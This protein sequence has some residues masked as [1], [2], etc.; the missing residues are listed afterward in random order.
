MGLQFEN[1]DISD[2]DSRK[3]EV[4]R[5][6]AHA[7]KTIGFF[8]ISGKTSSQA[9]RLPV[10]AEPVRVRTAPCSSMSGA[11]HVDE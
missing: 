6:L 5:Q 4:S 8:Y 10:V 9:D 2:F 3:E 7:A 1:V 11:F